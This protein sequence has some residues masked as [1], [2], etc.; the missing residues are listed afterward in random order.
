[1]NWDNYLGCVWVALWACWPGQ[2]SF[3]EAVRGLSKEITLQPLLPPCSDRGCSTSRLYMHKAEPSNCPYQ[4]NMDACLCMR[5]TYDLKSAAVPSICHYH[6][7]ASRTSHQGSPAEGGSVQTVHEED[8]WLAR[9]ACASFF[10]MK[11]DTIHCDKL[12]VKVC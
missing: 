1:M 11:A 2:R 10:V 3:T 5:T 4:Y 9:A 6:A 12:A 8:S 7:R